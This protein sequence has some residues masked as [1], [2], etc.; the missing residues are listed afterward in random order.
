MARRT[1]ECATVLEEAKRVAPSCQNMSEVGR[2]VA[3]ELQ[4]PMTP[5]AWRGLLGRNPAHK[6]EIA[7]ALGDGIVRDGRTL[8]VHGDHRIAIVS[9]AHA[10]FHDRR[11]IDAACQTIEEYRPTLLVLNG[12]M[13]DFYALSRFDKM[14]A[15]VLE[16]QEELD[17]TVAGVLRPLARAAGDARKVYVTGNHEERLIRYVNAHPEISSLR[18]LML[19]SLL[20][21]D[22]LG[23]DH[24]DYAVEVNGN[25]LVT[26]GRTVR[27][28]AGRS[29]QGEMEKA[30]FGISVVMGHVH[31]VAKVATATRSG[32]VWGIEA[33]CLCTLRPEYDPSPDWAHGMALVESTKDGAE[34][35]GVYL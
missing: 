5:A 14:P 34:G 12:D 15:R 28:W 21:F 20:R 24:V 32:L 2:K 11:A 19:S 23:I 9:D 27:K 26:H 17:A 1:V 7:A 25:V 29:V 35:R 4:T 8:H 3:A 10:P 6:G 33:G 13:V 18:S 30:R 31:R 22:D 16:L